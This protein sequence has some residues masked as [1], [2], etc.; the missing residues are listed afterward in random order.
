M[1]KNVVIAIVVVLVLGAGAAFFFQNQNK[2][3]VNN[4]VTSIKDSLSK[5]VSMECAYTNSAVGESKT[6]IKNGAIRSDYAG[7]KADQGGSVILTD[8]KI[9]MWQGKEGIVMD[10]PETTG[11]PEQA[12]GQ[13]Q[14][15]DFMADLEKYKDSCKPAVVSDSLFTPPSDVV[16]QDYSKMMQQNQTPPVGAGMTEEQTKQYMEQYANPQQ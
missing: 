7:Q 14:K 13:A 9:Y 8:K 6:Y 4:A 15:K 12:Q 11:T 16:F 2:S 3:G 1:P 10:I 5:A